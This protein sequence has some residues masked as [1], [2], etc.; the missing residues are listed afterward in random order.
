LARAENAESRADVLEEKL[1]KLIEAVKI[2]RQ[3]RSSPSAPV[4]FIVVSS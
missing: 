1:L 4:R 2:E 3:T